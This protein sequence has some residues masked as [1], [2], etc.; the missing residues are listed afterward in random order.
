MRYLIVLLCLYCLPSLAQQSPATLKARLKNSSDDSTKIDLYITISHQYAETQPD[1]AVYYCNEA[2]QLAEKVNN[3][4]G[5]ALI[6]LEL[7]RINA[8]HNHIELARRFENEALSIFRHLQYLPGIA[9]AYDELGLLDGQQK[10]LLSATSDLNQAMKYHQD[11]HD[12]TGILE[13]YQGLGTVYEQKGDIEKALTY[14]LRV[15]VQYEHRNNKTEA[16]FLLLERIGKLYLKKGDRPSAIRYLEEGIG[17]SN[18]PALR[19]TQIKLL[20]DEGK[21]YEDA[22]EGGKA[23]GKYKQSLEEAKK[24]NQPEEEAKALINIAGILKADNAA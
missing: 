1:S 4:R 9:S 19:D 22:G 6:L 23:L 24:Y 18:K 8:L 12:S 10:N 13:T 21:I 17:N 15:L 7:G 3:R 16:Y 11:T 14:Y 20:T 2:M 5:Q